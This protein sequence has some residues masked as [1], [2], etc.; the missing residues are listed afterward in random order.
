MLQ[1]GE[2]CNVPGFEWPKTD[3]DKDVVLDRILGFVRSS[4]SHFLL[5]VDDVPHDLERFKALVQALDDFKLPPHVHI[6]MTMM[7][8]TAEVP[9]VHFRGAALSTVHVP[10]LE[11]SEARLAQSDGV[12][13]DLRALVV[14]VLASHGRPDQPQP[15]R[16]QPRPCQRGL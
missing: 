4:S 16:R 14:V 11:P 9:E 8:G 15:S 2:T 6:L 10:P 1:L 3:E 12:L 13:D 7:T 5:V